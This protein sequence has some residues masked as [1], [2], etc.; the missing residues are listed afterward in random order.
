MLHILDSFIDEWFNE[1][2]K[3]TCQP[4]SQSDR[5]AQ[6]VFTPGEKCQTPHIQLVMKFFGFL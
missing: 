4:N 5:T 2:L 6:R 3:D 1:A